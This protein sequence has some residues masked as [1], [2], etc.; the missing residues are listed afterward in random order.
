MREYLLPYCVYYITSRYC[1][2]VCIWNF[3]EQVYKGVSFRMKQFIA[4]RLLQPK[5]DVW[6]WHEQ[7]A[8]RGSYG[9]SKRELLVTDCSIY[10]CIKEFKVSQTESPKDKSS[11]RRKGN[12]I[13]CWRS[14]ELTCK[15]GIAPIPFLWSSFAIGPFGDSIWPL[16]IIF[17]H[18]HVQ[19]TCFL[20]IRLVRKI[21]RHTA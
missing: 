5:K 15:T 18:V 2:P 13:N 6:K 8:L 14:F 21:N 20:V 3:T 12:T 10:V 11:E 19:T 17:Q 16:S 9:A 4:M 1:M 7:N